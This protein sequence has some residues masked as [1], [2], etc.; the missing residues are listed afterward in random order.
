MLLRGNVVLIYEAKKSQVGIFSVNTIVRTAFREE[1]HAIF[2]GRSF[3]DAE[4]PS[5]FDALI[6]K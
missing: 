4:R 1:C 5:V 6:A 3:E 2:F